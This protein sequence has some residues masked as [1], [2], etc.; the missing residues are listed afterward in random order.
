EGGT[1]GWG[2]LCGSLLG[3]T[4]AVGF[5]APYD[6][7]KQII[8]ELLQWYSDAELPNFMPE[9]PKA[10]VAIKTVSNSPLCHISVGKWTAAANKSLGSPERKERCARLTADVAMK[11]VSLLNAWK[12]GTFTSSLKLPSAMYGITGQHNCKEC[13]GSSVPTPVK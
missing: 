7:G 10:E 3:A 9:Q 8:N 11:T 4:V 13:H 5:V 6:V 12:D 2:T 1:V